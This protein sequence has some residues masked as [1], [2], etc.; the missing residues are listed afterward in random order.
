M[1]KYI[2]GLLLM[3]STLTVNAQCDYSKVTFNYTNNCGKVSFNFGEADTCLSYYLDLSNL[4]NGHLLTFDTNIVN[5]VIDTGLYTVQLLVSCKCFEDNGKQIYKMIYFGCDSGTVSVTN[6]L[7]LEPKLI[8]TYDMLGRPVEK[9][10]ND[11]PYIFLYNNGQRK[12]V[13]KRN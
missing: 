4:G 12:K 6:L 13:I 9:V 3:I 1:K 10:E 11:I 5:T 8:K 2:L 7:K